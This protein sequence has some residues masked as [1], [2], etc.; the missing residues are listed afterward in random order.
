MGAPVEGLTRKQ[1]LELLGGPVGGWIAPTDIRDGTAVFCPGRLEGKGD[2]RITDDTLMVEA[3]IACYQEHRDHLTAWEYR[4][5]FA[6]LVAERIIWIPERQREMVLLDR[7]ASAE[8]WH[9]RALLNSHRDPRFFGSNLHNITCGASMCAWPIGAV[10]AGDPRGAYDEAVAFFSAQTFS[11]GLEQAAVMA[12]ATA[13]ALA[14]GATAASTV[15]AALSLAKEATGEMIRAALDAAPPGAGRDEALP[16]IHAAVQKWHHKQA[17]ASNSGA[18]GPTALADRGMESRLR[19]SE[20]LPVALALLVRAGGDFVESVC[21]GVEYGED[22]DSIGAMAGSL[23][24]ALGGV[25]QIPSEW[26]TFSEVQNRRDYTS[27][28][29]SFT[30]AIREIV[31]ASSRRHRGRL[32]A[33]GLT[34]EKG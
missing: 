15:E 12:A 7:L 33:L 18:T 2:A 29:T 19:T 27:L 5:V 8:Q 30:Q 32:D 25:E 24:G 9:I 26:R 4:W 28:A 14:P 10:H 13:A 20:E 23:A 11:Y 6:P 34:P 31:S 3:L 17:R 21:S 16:A 22:A 1:I